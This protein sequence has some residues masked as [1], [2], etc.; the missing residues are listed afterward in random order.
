MGDSVNAGSNALRLRAL[1]GE[2]VAEQDLHIVDQLIAERGRTL[3][4]SRAW[5]FL[6]PLLC[7]MLHYDAAVTMAD[8]IAGLDALSCF[9]YLSAKLHLDVHATGLDNLAPKGAVVLVSNHPTGMADGI[10]LYDAVKRHR[11]DLMIFANRDAL[12]VNPRLAEIIVPVEWRLS[13]KSRAKTKETLARAARAFED[14]RAITLFPAGR[15]AYWQK[16]ELTE[17]PWMTSAVALARR[18][19]VPIVP[20]NMH[21]RNSGLFYFL[22]HVSTELRDI[23]VFH[24]LLNKQG[25]KFQVTFG[26]PIEPDLLDGDLPKVTRKLQDFCAVT[27]ARTPNARFSIA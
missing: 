11:S 10:A 23:T 6:R 26:M 27:L 5:P 18:Y 13:E 24:E 16:G 17:R 8:R 1:S 20:I 25:K 22:S 12:R 3:V 9:E 4:K 15:I 2:W 21:G 7:R 19:R 14:G